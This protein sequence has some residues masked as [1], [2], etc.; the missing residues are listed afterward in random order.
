MVPAWY[1]AE[2]GSDV[3]H[4]PRYDV[5]AGRSAVV[6]HFLPGARGESLRGT[7]GRS[8]QCRGRLRR[9]E[10]AADGRKHPRDNRRVPGTRSRIC[11]LHRLRLRWA[12]CGACTGV[13]VIADQEQPVE[14][15]D[16]SPDGDSRLAT[17]PPR[18]MSRGPRGTR[19]AG[20]YLVPRI[21]AVPDRPVAG[22]GA[23]DDACR[24]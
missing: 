18:T 11:L 23:N 20:R 5:L 1:A 14:G 9:R 24:T 6:D 16:L 4:G 13:V 19:R 3:G 10:P 12:G 2:R 7:P 21:G 22:I 17:V 8:P 15:C